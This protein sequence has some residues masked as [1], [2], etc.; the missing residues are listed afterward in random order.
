MT[1]ILY[2]LKKIVILII[3]LLITML[4]TIFLLGSTIDKI[5]VD[6]IRMQVV[7]SLSNSLSESQKLNQF[8]NMEQR[9]KFIDQQ[10]DLQIKSLGLDEPWYS[11]KKIMNT[12]FQI[13]TLNLGNSRFFTTHDGSSS[14]NE[15]IKEKLPNTILLFTSSSLAVVGLGIVIGSYLARREGRITDKFIAGLASLSLSV[16]PWWFSMIMIVVFSFFL[17]IFPARST[18]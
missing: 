2:I 8:D 16:P 12:L 9:Q 14:V 10:I 17:Q 15:L 13:L 3:V 1:I 7:N 4:L 5:M 6:N 11:P 18:A